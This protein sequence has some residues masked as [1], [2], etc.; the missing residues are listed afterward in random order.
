MHGVN[1]Q[2]TFLNPSLISFDIGLLMWY[3]AVEVQFLFAEH[4]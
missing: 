1:R 4:S 2:C 3:L